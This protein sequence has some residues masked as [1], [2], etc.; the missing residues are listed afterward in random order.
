MFKIEILAI[1]AI[2]LTLLVM[3]FCPFTS[4]QETI[5]E[6]TLIILERK[7]G[8]HVLCPFYKLKIF[9]NGMVELE[10]KGF[11]GEFK[12]KVI[13]NKVIKSKISQEQLMQII[14]EFE[15]IDF[16]SLKS[17]SENHTN[18]SQNDC[19]EYWFDSATSIT[20]F[21]IK[22]KT[23]QVEHYH[24]CR[25]SV[26]MEKLTDLEK[27][28]DEIVN[29]KQWIDCDKGKNRIS[30]SNQSNENTLKNLIKDNNAY[31]KSLNAKCKHVL[32]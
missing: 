5:P 1:K 7:P 28:I 14:S 29:I 6:D 8:F 9:G 3:I 31:I 24:G 20:T 15:K 23:K 26:T 27:K 30:I 2:L 18:N 17:T 12:E 19:P 22:G 13:T 4:A 32:F 16:Y 25:G 21:T 10:S 11:S